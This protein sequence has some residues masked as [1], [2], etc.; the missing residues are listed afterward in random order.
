LFLAPDILDDRLHLLQELH[1]GVVVADLEAVAVLL[2]GLI[3]VGLGDFDADAVDV[4][5]RGRR[6]ASLFQLLVLNS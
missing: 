6:L 2:L 4:G 1:E 5:G 3:E